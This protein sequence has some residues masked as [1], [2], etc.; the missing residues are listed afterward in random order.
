MVDHARPSFFD[1]LRDLNRKCRSHLSE[2]QENIL[3]AVT[4]DHIYYLN[5]KGARKKNGKM[6]E[7]WNKT[8]DKLILL[9]ISCMLEG[10]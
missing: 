1:V 2:L 8:D 9:K 4:W 6:H 7:V 5:G 10:G 3:C